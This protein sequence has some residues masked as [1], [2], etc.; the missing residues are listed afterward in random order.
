M[1]YNVQFDLR[2][3]QIKSNYNQISQFDTSSGNWYTG[4]GQ[5]IDVSSSYTI[6]ASNATNA[7]YILLLNSSNANTSS[8]TI[9]SSYIS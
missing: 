2:G 4:Q 3:T 1:P 5:S 6:S 8:V 9:S 7:Q